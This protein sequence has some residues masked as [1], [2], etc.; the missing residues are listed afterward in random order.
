MKQIPALGF[1]PRSLAQ[2]HASRGD[3][4]ALPLETKDLLSEARC[5]WRHEPSTAN[6]TFK[7]FMKCLEQTRL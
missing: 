4:S 5:F 7:L 3:I 6:S 2:T 1:F